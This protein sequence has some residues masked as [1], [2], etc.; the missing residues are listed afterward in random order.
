[1]TSAIRSTLHIALPWMGAGSLWLGAT[2]TLSAQVITGTVR[3]DDTKRPLAGVEVLMEKPKRQTV[4][5]AEGRFVFDGVPKGDRVLLFRSVGFRPIRYGLRVGEADTVR[6]D[7]LLV[8]FAVVLDPIKVNAPASNTRLMGID[9]RVRLGV[10]VFVDSAELRRSEAV[11]LGDLIG[12]QPGLQVDR[13]RTGSFAMGVGQVG[14]FGEKCPMS[15]IVDGAVIYRSTGVQIH[16]KQTAPVPLA[17]PPDLNAFLGVAD[18]QAIEIYRR[19]SEVPV[20]FGG[21]NT[22]CGVI[23]FWTRRAR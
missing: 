14:P 6:A 15:I 2:V 9:D 12:R 5:D 1:M 22:A 4:T 10:G 11:R 18:L 17:P 20:E 7:A 3:Q 16:T 21:R 19:A 23:V 8:G 13:T